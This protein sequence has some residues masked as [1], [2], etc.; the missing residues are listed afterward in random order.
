MDRGQWEESARIL[1]GGISVGRQQWV[2]L[3]KRER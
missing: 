3:E 1:L 2:K